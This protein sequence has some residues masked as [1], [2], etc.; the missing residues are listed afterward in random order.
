[1]GVD[2]RPGGGETGVFPSLEQP[3][4]GDD[5]DV[6]GEG[7]A[8]LVP[9]VLADDL[10]FVDLVVGP[11]VRVARLV[12]EDGLEDVVLE[13][14]LVREL[15]LVVGAVEAHLQL[16]GVGRVLFD[17]V[18]RFVVGLAVGVA[19]GLVDHG[20]AGDGSLRAVEVLV[21]FPH[22]GGVGVGDGY[23][24]REFGGAEDFA[25]SEGGGAGE[26]AVRCVGSGRGG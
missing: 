20:E 7:V 26:E 16:G 21:V 19:G 1:M 3:H 18:H 9:P 13:G 12:E 2:E 23:V 14:D 8:E 4:P 22:V 24:V 10:G 15:R 5:E 25:L 11:E 17:V 6:V